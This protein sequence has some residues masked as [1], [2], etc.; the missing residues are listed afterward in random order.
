MEILLA[1]PEIVSDLVHDRSSDLAR[2]LLAVREVGNEGEG[3]EDDARRSVAV[4][5]ALAARY[6]V[7]EAVELAAVVAP[8][9]ARCTTRLD[10]EDQLVG[11]AAKR[12]GERP[13]RLG[14][15]VLDAKDLPARCGS[16]WCMARHTAWH[17]SIVRVGRE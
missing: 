17:I 8:S 13:K 2:E 14:D 10:H 15:Q 1:E 11:G 3:V 9:T 4:S 6:P 7:E 12:F 5:A 16:D